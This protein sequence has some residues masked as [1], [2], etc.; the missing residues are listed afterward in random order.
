VRTPRAK[1]RL[2]QHFLHDPSILKRIADATGAAEGDTMLEIGPGPGGLTRAL[3]RTGAR[4][5]AIERDADLAAFLRQQ[6]TGAEVIAGDAL[7]LDWFET[8]GRPD[9]S[10]WIIA[11]NIPYNISTPLIDQALRDPLPG[12]VVFLVQREVADRLRAEP[13]TAEYGALSVGVQ[14]VCLVEQLFLVGKGSFVPPPKVDSAVVRLT[15][16]TSPL[17]APGARAAF[18]RFVV[19]LFGLRRKQLAGALRQVTGR[20][21]AAIGP[22]L[23]G[24]GLPHQQRA[25]TLTPQAFWALYRGLVDESPGAC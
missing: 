14:S 5:V 17:V 10:R 7:S 22:V 11:G 6:D 21:T 23:D 18:R 2:G 4:V 8:A 3:V 25:E 15:P 19:A 16:L 1:R 20:S 9:P 13:G 24:M 12:R